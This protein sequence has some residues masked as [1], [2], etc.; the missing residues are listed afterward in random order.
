MGTVL[1]VVRQVLGEDLLEMAP[2]EDED[3]IEA[4]W[5]DGS[6]ETLGE[7]VRSRRWNRRFDDSDAICAEDFV[8][9]GGELPCHGLE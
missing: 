4:L 2:T 5:A 7:G 1:V 3:S 8:E 9:A 6:D